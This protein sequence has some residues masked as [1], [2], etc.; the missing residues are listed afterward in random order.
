[1]KDEEKERRKMELYNRGKKDRMKPKGFSF[2]TLSLN[3]HSSDKLPLDRHLF[4]FTHRSF[5]FSFR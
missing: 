4:T 3:S 2:G 5:R 1:M